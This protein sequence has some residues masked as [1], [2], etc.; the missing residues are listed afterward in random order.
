MKAPQKIG[1]L[2]S[3]GLIIFVYSSSASGEGAALS[4]ETYSPQ[5]DPAYRP[6]TEQTVR[7]DLIL[8]TPQ[9]FERAYSR[10]SR[11]GSQPRA[12]NQSARYL[13]DSSESRPYLSPDMGYAG[14]QNYYGFYRGRYDP[15]LYAYRPNSPRLF[16]WSLIPLM[17]LDNFQNHNSKHRN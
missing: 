2:L 14:Y 5:K 17:N 9:D 12:E 10:E 7:W 6:A 15:W 8:R 1:I 3:I 16:W 11:Q 4:W 13:N